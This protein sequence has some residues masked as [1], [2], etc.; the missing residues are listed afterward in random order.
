V[1]HDRL[2]WWLAEAGIPEPLPPLAGDASA[3]VVVVGGGYT[4]MWAAWHLAEAGATVVLLEAEVCGTGPSGRNGGFCSSL[5]LQ[6]DPA[7]A[8]APAGRE[9]VAAIGSWCRAQAVDAWFREAP[10]WVVSTAPAQDEMVA[11]HAD[12]ERAVALDAAAVRS[13][14]SS[15]VFR[16]AVE[17]ACGA[18][19]H[20]ARLAL[21]L[22]ARLVERGVRVYERSQVRALRGT[23]AETD[24]GRVRAGA[25]LVTAGVRGAALRPLRRRLT[26]GSSHVVITEPVPDVIEQLGWTGGEA[27][28]DG[29]ALLHYTRTT[30]D[31]RIV[32]GWAGGRMA[33][34]TRTGR[35]MEV[36]AEVVA[37]AVAGLHRWFPQLRGR[38]IEHAWGG[39][40]DV[41]PTHMPEIRTLGPRAWAAF[42][43]TGNGVGPSQL[44]GRVLAGLALGHGT[45][46]PLLDPPARRVPP[47]PLRVT[48][49]AVLR[50][51]LVRKEAIEEAGGDPPLLLRALAALPARMGMRIV[52]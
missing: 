21:G 4:G 12:G 38:R 47:E 20:P 42:G 24:G 31:G 30:R 1:L 16:D 3:D 45:D 39:P 15:P 34:G 43:Y 6:V 5:D 23:V 33:A 17:V 48:G 44:L 2:G 40:I 10:H 50:R 22:R 36:D 25:A 52:R 37:G 41:A 28:S 29:R 18:T 9:S 32:F 46:L 35:R 13:R 49:A 14:C 7:S 26:V 11:A 19:V 27:I 8:L 51:A